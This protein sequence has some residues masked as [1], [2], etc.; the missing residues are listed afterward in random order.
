MKTADFLCALLSELSNHITRIERKNNK[1][2]L[3]A[4]FQ[5]RILHRNLGKMTS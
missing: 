4:R 3:N 1:K 2:Y 5:I